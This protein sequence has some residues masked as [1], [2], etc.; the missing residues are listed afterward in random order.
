[1]AETPNPP[2]F[3]AAVWMAVLTIGVPPRA[4]GRLA[5]AINSIL[6]DT[7]MR[8]QLERSGFEVGALLRPPQTR[9]FRRAEQAR[10]RR[11]LQDTGARLG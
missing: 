1:M 11:I 9:P 8:S 3:A 6:S 7:N 2:D 4:R 5:Y 10:W